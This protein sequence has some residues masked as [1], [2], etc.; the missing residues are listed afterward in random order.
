MTIPRGVTIRQPGEP[1]PI[2]ATGNVLRQ[3][4]RCD[5]RNQALK[6]IED[7]LKLGYREHFAEPHVSPQSRWA[8]LSTSSRL[9]EIS[10]WLR[11]ECYELMDLVQVSGVN[12]RGD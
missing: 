9:Q 3:A 1:V 10:E 5:N 6:L 12:T 2:H 11:V 7:A 4:A 8:R